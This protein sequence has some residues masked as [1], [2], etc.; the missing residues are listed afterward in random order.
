MSLAAYTIPKLT[1]QTKNFG[2]R[3]IRCTG[4]EQSRR[5]EAR[6]RNPVLGGFHIAMLAVLSVN[7]F[8][9]TPRHRLT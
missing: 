1:Y 9:R 5:L 6:K 7:G 4:T 8:L 3:C 2:I